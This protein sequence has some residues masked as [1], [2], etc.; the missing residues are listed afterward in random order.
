MH[1]ASRGPCRCRCAT[2]DLEVA[3]VCSPP[4]LVEF[5]CGVQGREAEN[6][7]LEDSLRQAWCRISGELVA[8]QRQKL[9]RALVMT[10]ARDR[11]NSIRE[12]IQVEAIRE[13]YQQRIELSFVFSRTYDKQNT[14]NVYIFTAQRLPRTKEVGHLKLCTK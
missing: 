13:R 11:P 5:L 2:K 12:E 10:L 6:L 7:A 8:T 4:V 14:P 9:S 3:L 1:G